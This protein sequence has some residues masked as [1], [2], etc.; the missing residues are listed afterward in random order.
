MN[1]S[2]SPTVLV[3]LVLTHSVELPVKNKTHKTFKMITLQDSVNTNATVL[4]K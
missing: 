3:K 1:T 4:V 2:K